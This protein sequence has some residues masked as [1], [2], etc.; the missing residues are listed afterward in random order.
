LPRVW[1]R[2]PQPHRLHVSYP[3]ITDEPLGLGLIFPPPLSA[4]TPTPSPT[5]S[6]P[7]ILTRANLL[8]P[9]I[10][11]PKPSE[12][13]SPKQTKPTA[14]SLKTLQPGRLQPKHL[15]HTPK[16]LLSESGVI[17]VQCFNRVPHPKDLPTTMMGVN[18]YHVVM[19][20]REV[21]I[22]CL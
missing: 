5:V 9:R 2:S 12:A 13:T 8:P 10:P 7:G 17:F 18:L 6:S 21:G 15:Q 19:C 3:G 14:S 11:K 16:Q 22:F 4:K 20:G 1:S